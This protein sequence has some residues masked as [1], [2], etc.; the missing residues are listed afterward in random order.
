M[1]VPSTK[2]FSYGNIVG[3]R[4]GFTVKFSGFKDRP[5]INFKTAVAEGKQCWHVCSKTP[6]SR[7]FRMMFP[8]FQAF[9]NLLGSRAFTEAYRCVKFILSL[10]LLVLLHQGK[11]TINI[12]KINF[13][14][15][16]I[17]SSTSKYY[18]AIILGKTKDR[19]KIIVNLHKILLFIE[20]IHHNAFD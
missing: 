13:T 2:I 11:R 3:Q 9:P 10:D 7:A 8:S 17:L 18:I 6:A 19:Y 4:F 20:I 15:N 1:P 16:G 12:L 14:S 5:K